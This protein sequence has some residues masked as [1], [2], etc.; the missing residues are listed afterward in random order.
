M[1]KNKKEISQEVK[2]VIRNSYDIA[3]VYNDYEVKP[4]HMM[5]SILDGKANTCIMLFERIGIDIEDLYY[6]LDSSLRN[7]MN[8]KI[9]LSELI[10][11]SIT[12][13]ILS[14]T[15]KISEELQSNNI[16]TTHLLLSILKH[17][18]T[19]SKILND[20][21][22]EY[23]HLKMKLKTEIN[24][25]Y[26]APE[27]GERRPENRKR[28]EGSTK[29]P[30]LDNFSRNLNKLAQEGKLDPVVGRKLE[31]KRVAQILTRRRKNNVIIAGPGGTGKSAIVEGLALLIVNGNAPRVLMDKKIYSL[32]MSSVVAGT[33][34]RGDFEN[35]MKALMEEL[36][37]NPDIILFIDELHTIVGA[38]AAA[39]SMDAANIFKPALAR[40]ELQVIGAT[41]LDEY[42][43]HIEKDGALVR[44]F[45]QVLL[46]E[47]TVYETI[48]ILNNIKDKYEAHH[49]VT[50]TKE[51]IEECVKL[52]V[53]YVM[54]RA[55]PDKAIDIMDEAGAATNVN[56]QVPDNIKKIEEK[57]EKIRIEK[58]NV[59]RTQKYEEAAKLRDEERKLESALDKAK[60]EWLSKID[61]DRK[62][63]DVPSVTEVVSMMTGIPIT[64]ISV[65]ENKKLL[66]LDKYLSGK[67]IG[68][69]EAVQRV[70]DSI[71]VSRMGIK[72]PNR[73][74][75]TF[76]FLGQ[77]GVG[78][79]H[80]AKQ[81]AK[82][83]FNDEDSLIRIDMSEYM[84][85]HTVSKLI[86]SP[87]GYIGYEEGGQLTEKVRRKP[88][89]VIL[90]DEIEKAHRDVF[91][92][93]LQLLDEGRLTDGLGR[94]VDFRN[95][96]VILTSNVGIK[97]LSQFG[98]GIGFNTASSV[99]NEEIKAKAV[100]EKEMKD[101][102][103][104]EFLNRI[105]ETI[106]FNSLTKEDIGKIIHNEIEI[107]EERLKDK[108]FKIKL[109]KTA[110]D[111]LVEKGYDK[112]Y[113]ARP[114]NRA[115]HKFVEIPIAQEML[116]NKIKDG[117]TINVSYN[118]KDDV[119]VIKTGTSK[120]EE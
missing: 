65:E 44:R 85:K 98:T 62:V 72:N 92:V 69:E 70:C 58:N 52:S 110:I 103:P 76:I 97:K 34:Y 80:L 111:Y 108:G 113:G 45:Q 91:N 38:G 79:T 19:T 8:P 55:L 93:L 4:E 54:D 77:S 116:K 109:T 14:D 90:F 22:L 60:E 94:K 51:A 114:L 87:P 118:K 75:G 28:T 6:K 43:E 33:K 101:K 13:T 86:G 20:M 63:V 100:L 78:K 23:N 112:E 106:I 67:V 115:I 105:D 117:D 107:V 95:T 18:S 11:S 81:L 2:T 82:H 56:L 36:K 32:E 66:N 26:D 7:D 31:I 104:P 1:A 15:N 25:S 47:P 68:Q 84:E 57:R 35:R 48:T 61:K 39:G 30:V 9:V 102:F 49:K 74:Q 21:N 59:V 29:T 119:I 99:I 42:R 17:E 88:Y 41:T 96:L 24:A 3:K 73:P 89:A 37:A 53:R 5:I 27:E 120:N 46:E 64:N 50:Y 71:K 83:V 10:P 12:K 16:D 40:G